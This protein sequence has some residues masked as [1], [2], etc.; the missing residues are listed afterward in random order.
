MITPPPTGTSEA[1]TFGPLGAPD[2]LVAVDE[3]GAELDAGADVAGADDVAA[4]EAGTEVEGA[5][6]SPSFEQAPRTP[7][8]PP[9]SAARPAARNTVRRVVAGAWER[10]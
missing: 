6:A 4:D 8:P 1:F 2:V 3:G 10:G 7:T 9:A 5:A